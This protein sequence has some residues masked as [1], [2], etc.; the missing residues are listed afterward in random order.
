MMTELT[1]FLREETI[2]GR[3]KAARCLMPDLDVSAES[4]DIPVRKAKA[5]RLLCR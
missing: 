1:A 2:S 3:N 4:G 5:F